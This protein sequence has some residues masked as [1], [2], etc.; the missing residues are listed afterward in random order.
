MPE[1]DRSNY[2]PVVIDF[3]DVLV[4]LAGGRVYLDS[5]GVVLEPSLE[6]HRNAQ[7]VRTRVM[8]VAK[9]AK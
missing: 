8:H 1:Q 3:R 9:E 6:I 7:R 4:I 2:V 5:V